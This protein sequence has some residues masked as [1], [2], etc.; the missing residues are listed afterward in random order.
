MLVDILINKHQIVRNI[1][2]NSPI[3]RLFIRWVDKAGISENCKSSDPLADTSLQIYHCEPIL[4][5]F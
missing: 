2:L 5:F 4:T 1:R 3:V